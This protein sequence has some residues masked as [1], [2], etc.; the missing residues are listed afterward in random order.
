[1][2]DGW[3]DALKAKL[4]G[5]IDFEGQRAAEKYNQIILSIGTFIAFVVGYILQSM[6]ATF[7]IYAAGLVIALVVVVPP[8]PCYN[9]H[10]VAWLPK[11]KLKENS[12]TDQK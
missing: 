10:P 6:V 7:S 3:V 11:L 5:K 8:W 12:K 2:I 9:K 1:T 4:E